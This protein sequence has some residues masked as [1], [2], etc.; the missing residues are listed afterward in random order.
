MKCSKEEKVITLKMNFTSSMNDHGNLTL[1][2]LSEKLH[3]CSQRNWVKVR[4]LTRIRNKI[5]MKWR[6]LLYCWW[7]CKLMQLLWKTVWRVLKNTGNKTT[8]W[9]KNPTQGVYPE[10]TITEKDI[11]TPIFIAALFTIAKTWKKPRCPPTDEWIKKLWY[12]YTLE[13]YSGIKK[14]QFLWGGWT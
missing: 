3:E 10:E 8:T 7:E 2:P 14:G 1:P 13:Y 4:C 9:P 11:C 6:M 5:V 12:I